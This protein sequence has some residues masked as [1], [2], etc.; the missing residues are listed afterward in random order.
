MEKAMLGNNGG[1]V[2]TRF[3]PDAL[4]RKYLE[5]RDKRLRKEG[6][7]QYRTTE[8][9][10]ARY[11]ED[12]YIEHQIDR[13]PVDE[14]VD[15]LVIG[16]GFGGLLAAAR[17]IEAGIRNIRII[18]KAGDFGGT[19]YWNR[20]PGAA[21]DIE[22]YVYMPLLEELN[23]VPSEKYAR[24]PEIFAHAQAIGRHYGLY[25]RALFQ[26]EITALRWDETAS[27]WIA[28]T[29]KSD[30]IKA[31]FVC[32]STGPLQ[33]PKLPGIPGIETFEGHTFH[34]SR[35]DYAY[36]GGNSNGNLTGLKDKR[37][38]IIGTGATAIQAIPYLG[39]WAKHLYVFQRTPSAVDVRGNQPTDPAWAKT[40]KPGWQKERMDN[41]N[42]LVSGGTADVDLVSDG[43]TEILH[44]IGVEISGR[45]E[46][47]RR[48]LADFA[49]MEQIR[50]RI[51]SVVRDKATAE[52]LK[53]YFNIMCKRPCF[54]DSYLDTYNRP[55][56]TL[57]HTDGR[58]V[59]RVTRRGVVANGQE[60]EIDCLIYATGFEFQTNF[61]GRNGYEIHGRGGLPL[62]EKWKD[63]LSTLHGYFTRGFP[64]CFVLGNGQTANTPNFTHML[65]ESSKHLA[66]VV[67]HCLDHQ[68]KAIEPTAEAEQAWVDHCL[69]FAGLRRK[70]DLECT[71]GYYNN[72]GQPSD[73][74]TVQNNFYPGG[75]LLFLD[76]IAAWRSA[77]NLPGL[78]QNHTDTRSEEIVR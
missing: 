27:R 7:D 24:G 10:L 69:S 13:A 18:E 1:T 33:K 4:H 23:Y 46:T 52:A 44:G 2:D 20:Y 5:E 17:L 59:E 75:S 38:G 66:Y 55:N 39:E 22:S 32:M 77:G 40:L 60:Y 15:V 51:D 54:H 57:V 50:A 28:A 65:N 48:Q 61:A 42:A 14:T 72:E 45:D 34:T 78:E 64:N 21:C 56:V 8:G 35:W 37:V 70:Y 36:T 67:K 31:R 53:P 74:T 63:G 9:E 3:D 16:G 73:V 68:I 41:F 58:G 11:L 71:P 19:W 62:S 26:T 29:D 76:K 25:A 30:A 47:D 43:W 12:P 6:T 49:K